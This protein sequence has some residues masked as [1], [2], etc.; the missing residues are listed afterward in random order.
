MGTHLKILWT[1]TTLSKRQHLVHM[2]KW[3]VLIS[4]LRNFCIEKM[5]K[6]EE[7]SPVW[8]HSNPGSGC[9]PPASRTGPPGSQCECLVSRCPLACLGDCNEGTQ[10]GGFS[11]RN[12][13][14]LSPE[15]ENPKSSSQRGC[16]L[17]RLRG[18]DMVQAPPWLSLLCFFTLPNPCAHLCV[19][20]PLVIRTPVIVD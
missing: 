11:H 7:K 3:G 1:I 5:L 19:Q 13:R 16:F 15:A 20:T 10:T 18:K 17:L 12:V 4:M 9:E 14:S 2:H 6:V 8:I